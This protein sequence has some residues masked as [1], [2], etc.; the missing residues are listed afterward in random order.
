MAVSFKWESPWCLREGKRNKVCGTP[1]S[2][3]CWRHVTQEKEI[4]GNS[5]GV[6]PKTQQSHSSVYTQK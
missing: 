5:L 2:S 1:A 6:R 3:W 4:Q